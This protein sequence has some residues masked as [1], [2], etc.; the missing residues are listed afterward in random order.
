MTITC[1]PRSEAQLRKI[2]SELRKAGLFDHYEEQARGETVVIA[3]RTRTFDEREKVK[4][5]LQD[6]GITE[7]TYVEE[8]VA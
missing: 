2:A 4:S 7:F 5:I 3:V 1:F 6:A 8:D